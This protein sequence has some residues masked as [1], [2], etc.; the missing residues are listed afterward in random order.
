MTNENEALRL[1]STAARV[2]QLKYS[3][4]AL[5][6]MDA[7][8]ATERDV[9]RACMTATRAISQPGGRWRLEGGCDREGEGLAVCVVIA[10]DVVVVTVF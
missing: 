9:E 4:H 7:A 5:D 3:G 10:H 8:N 2:G 1:A 6:E